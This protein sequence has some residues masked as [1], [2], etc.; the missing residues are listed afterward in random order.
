MAANDIYNNKDGWDRFVDNL[1]DVLQEPSKKDKLVRRGVRKYWCKNKA[2]LKYFKEMINRFEVDDL[3]YIR[4]LRMS[5]V[6]KM[7][8]STLIVT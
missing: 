3:S 4:R 8:R 6:L 5:Q 7:L 1:E 2:N